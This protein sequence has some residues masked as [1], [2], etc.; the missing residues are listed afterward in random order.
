VQHPQREQSGRHA[1][2]AQAEHHTPR[3]DALSSKVQHATGLG[4]CGKKQIGAYRQCGLDAKAKNQQ[5]RH[6]RAPA[7][8]GETHDQAHHKTRQ[9]KCKFVHMGATVLF[10]YI[11]PN[12]F[13]VLAICDL[14]ITN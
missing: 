12:Y 8:A 10:R 4:A 9:D 3:N 2:Q 7:Y 11:E 14:A 13:L 1:A 5:G 6:Q